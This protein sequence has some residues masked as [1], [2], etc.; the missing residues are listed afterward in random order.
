MVALHGTSLSLGAPVLVR[1]CTPGPL[2]SQGAAVRMGLERAP[3]LVLTL[4]FRT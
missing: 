1:C 3:A 2:P 4:S